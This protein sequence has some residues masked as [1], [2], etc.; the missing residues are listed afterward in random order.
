MFLIRFLPPRTEALSI[1]P[2]LALW[3]NGPFGVGKTTVAEILVERWPG[4][5]LIDPERI[6]FV[7]QRTFWRSRD[8]QD[9]AQWRDLTVRRVTR[10]ARKGHSS[11]STDA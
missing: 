8:Y 2:T 6:G 5:R 9:V 10:A 1:P 7:I 3:L 11:S 4:A